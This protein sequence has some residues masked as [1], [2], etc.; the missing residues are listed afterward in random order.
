[1]TGKW[2]LGHRDR[3]YLP[4]SRGFDHFYGHVTG[5][6]GYWDHV[7]GGGLDWQRNGKT[8]REEGYSTHLIADEAVRLIQLARP[9]KAD[10]PV[11]ELQR[12][13]PAERSPAGGHRALQPHRQPLSTRPCRDG[14]RAGCSHRPVGGRTESRED[15]GQHAHLVHERQRR[16]EPG[17]F[18][19]GSAQ[20]VE[21]ARGLVRQAAA[22]DG[23]RVR[24]HQQPGRRR[25]QQALSQR[26]AVGLRRRRAGTVPHLLAR[27]CWHPVAP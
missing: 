27:S 24:T 2:H 21:A 9:R 5:G 10:A 4:N 14:Q 3:D 12:P 18:R 6:I 19:A 8:L 1:M 17:G 16:S 11:C 23:P 25:R 26:E 20:D 15:A 7:H 13:A 22:A